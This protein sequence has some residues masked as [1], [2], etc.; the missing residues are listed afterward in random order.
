MKSKFFKKLHIR[1]I[2]TCFAIVAGAFLA[3]AYSSN[4]RASIAGSFHWVP[5]LNDEVHANV[6][7][8]TA[9]GPSSPVSNHYVYSTVTVYQNTG[10]SAS[11]SQALSG[12]GALEG[13]TH[14]SNSKLNGVVRATGSHNGT[15]NSSNQSQYPMQYASTALKNPYVN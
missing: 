3:S 4:L 15:A 9:G 11:V 7:V 12:A 5:I 6:S 10:K 8:N 14:A 2:V 13:W 1:F